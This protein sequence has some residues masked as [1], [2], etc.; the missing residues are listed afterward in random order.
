[1]KEFI[2]SLLILSALLNSTTGAVVM[3][4][5]RV[6]DR[7][8]LL[9]P[10]DGTDKNTIYVYWYFGEPETNILVISLNPYGNQGFGTDER[11]KGRVSMT[12]YSLVI[13]G[14]QEQ[15]FTETFTCVIKQDLK[16]IATKKY[17]LTKITVSVKPETS[18]LAGESLSLACKVQSPQNNAQLQIHWLNPQREKRANGPTP[19]DLTVDKVTGRHNGEW[20]CVVTSG[21]KESYAKISVTVLDLS[22]APLY[23]QYTSLSRS[24]RLNIPCSIPAPLSWKNF[25]EKGLQGGHWSFV[26]R[27]SPGDRQ[28]LFNLSVEDKLTW[29][30]EQERGLSASD[31]EKKELSLSKKG[32]TEADRGEYVCALEFK[33]GVTLERSIH[34]EV[35]E[36]L[37]SSGLEIPAGQQ[38]NLTCSLGQPLHADLQVKWIPPKSWCLPSLG[39]DPHPARLTIPEVVDED[40]RRWGCELWRNKTQ[41]TSADITLK[42][43]PMSVWLLVTICGATVIF[44]LLLILTVILLRRRRQRK[45]TPRHPKHKFCRCKNPK[46]KGFH[47]S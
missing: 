9:M 43:A 27:L 44:I 1:M 18:V 40:C 15:D 23:P 47:R 22:P 6:G 26:P 14:I 28:R 31:P 35:L 38:V 19:G 33:N 45:M 46:P 8:T 3:A 36:I 32:V 34:V 39:P 10:M 42:I 2:Q 20:T 24:T 7:I 5:H 11:W 41:L 25:K 17:K 30:V 13:K 12:D 37:S 4:Y 16:T 29:K 21:G